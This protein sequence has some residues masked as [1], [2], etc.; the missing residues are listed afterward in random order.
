LD[1]TS[2]ITNWA[3]QLRVFHAKMKS[4]ELGIPLSTSPVQPPGLESKVQSPEPLSPLPPLLT[5][6]KDV[7]KFNNDLP[8]TPW[9]K[10]LFKVSSSPGFKSEFQTPSIFDTHPNGS[11]KLNFNIKLEP[12]QSVGNPSIDMVAHIEKMYQE[13]TESRI[14]EKA[15][16]GDDLSFEEL[17]YFDCLRPCLRSGRP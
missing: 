7:C 9:E 17:L 12:F 10:N 2:E 15:E 1:A 14:Q 11:S 16:V 5:P 8:F 13:A 6:T 4:E 3:R